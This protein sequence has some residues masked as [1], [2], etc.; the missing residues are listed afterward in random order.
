MA[1]HSIGHDIETEIMVDENRVLI[2][3]ALQADVSLCPYIKVH[4]GILTHDWSPCRE[5][6][7]KN[8]PRRADKNIR[9]RLWMIR[10]FRKPICVFLLLSLGVHAGLFLWFV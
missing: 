8:A 6:F 3:I 5:S 10:K 4:V 9:S 2:D 7:F 1:A